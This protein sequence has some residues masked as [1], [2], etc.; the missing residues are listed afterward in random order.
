MIWVLWLFW[1]VVLVGGFVGVARAINGSRRQLIVAVTILGLALSLRLGGQTF[2]GLEYEDAYVYAASARTPDSTG[3]DWRGLRVC[4]V[5]S[6]DDCREWEFFPG[7]LPG[8]P[9][10]L[11]AVM[12]VVG[13]HAS[14]APN[15]GAVLSSLA[16]VFVWWA[17]WVITQSFAAAAGAGILFA[18]TPVF[19]LYGGSAVSESASAVPL[20]LAFGAVSMIRK[21]QGGA[22]HLYWAAFA[23]MS[24]LLALS[25]RRENAVL[26]LVLPVSLLLS[27]ETDRE[28]TRRRLLQL[29]PW[30]V[31]GLTA[32]AFLS[33]SLVSEVGEYGQVS[34]GVSRL[35]G[36]LP[37]IL[38]A[39]VTLEWFGVLGI[40]AVAPTVRAAY[41][42]WRRG[43]SRTC[44]PTVLAC[45]VSALMMM[46][47]YA[48]HIRSTYQLMGV[49]VQPFDF[50]RYLSNV[51]VPM[52]ILAGVFLAA[53]VT[54]NMWRTRA[55]VRAISALVGIVYVAASVAASRNLRAELT[56]VEHDVRTLPALQAL[57]VAAMSDY[58]QPI[59]TLESMVV[60]AFA[61][62][63]ARVIS[64]PFLS[65]DHVRE[66]NGRMLYVHQDH[67]SSEA[68]RH[69][70]GAAFDV[71]PKV[72]A[73]RGQGAGWKIL[74]FGDEN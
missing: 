28:T 69:R 9:A 8:F 36:V 12:A 50:L 57:K 20:A 42:V 48:A 29:A 24:S 14:V 35:V 40:V 6:L 21:A 64:L 45:A 17:T 38:R 70:Y 25:I 16:A 54:A 30:M 23:L 26:L 19:S 33:R 13:E 67:Y 49:P 22:V 1:A 55:S 34:F 39:L 43:G 63:S 52:S 68:D 66:F 65:V 41:V 61:P 15:V 60:R 71:L 44:E 18:V 58:R 74:V 11:R 10:A 27:V 2:Y 53:I 3:M 4:A 46:V 32:A 31:V 37:V 62:P 56:L 47:L 7:H 51:A 5:G 72:A 73:E 59:V